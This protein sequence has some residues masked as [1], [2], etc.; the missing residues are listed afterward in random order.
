MSVSDRGRCARKLLAGV[1]IITPLLWVSAADAVTISIGYQEAGV[2]GG[3]ITPEVAGAPPV[4]SAAGAY[5]TFTNVSTTG[6]YNTNYPASPDVLGSTTLNLSSS[7]DGTVNIYVTA[8][9]ITSPA[10]ILPWSSFFTENLLPAGWT[11]TESTYID[12]ADGVFT[13][14]GATVTQL[15]SATFPPVPAAQP[16]IQTSVAGT[17]SNGAGYSVTELFTVTSTGEG[18]DLSTI[19]LQVGAPGPVAGA[20]LPGMVLAVAGLLGWRRKR[21]SA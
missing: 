15:G 11:V 13:T 21:K 18:T 3:A 8:S 2:N 5:G 9:D 12:T 16:I 17:G 1:A 14:A 20:G 19:D 6:L 7:S 10:G 4:Q